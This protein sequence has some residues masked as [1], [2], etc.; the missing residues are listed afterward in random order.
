[1]HLNHGI[2]RKKNNIKATVIQRLSRNLEHFH[3]IHINAVVEKQELKKKKDWTKCANKNNWH[4]EH[5]WSEIPSCTLIYSAQFIEVVCC[6]SI[7]FFCFVSKISLFLFFTI[8]QNVFL[9]AM[10]IHQ[11]SKMT[12]DF[13]SIY[14]FDYYLWWVMQCILWKKKK[15]LWTF[16]WNTI[17]S[18][19]LILPLYC[20]VTWK[21]G[22]GH[23]NRILLQSKLTIFFL[24][25]NPPS[26]E[27]HS[28]D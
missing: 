4:V 18:I 3:T 7:L 6:S 10:G 14:Y 16:Q 23:A 9:L 5:P 22:S 2:Q 28:S 24:L 17:K 13:V 11:Q 8:S 27:L 12:L 20:I 21:I 15:F 19:Y 1:M 25:L 26:N